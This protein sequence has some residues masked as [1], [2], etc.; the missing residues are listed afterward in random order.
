MK[1]FRVFAAGKRPVRVEA[2]T[3]F[4]AAVMAIQTGR[5]KGLGLLLR[6]ETE[7]PTIAWYVSSI[8]ACKAAGMWRG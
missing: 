3:P 4:R 1:P 6:I 2:R 5:F 8:K 7:P